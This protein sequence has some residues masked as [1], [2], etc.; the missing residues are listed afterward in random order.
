MCTHE[1]TSEHPLFVIMS[2]DYDYESLPTN[3]VGVHMTAGAVA[4][5]MEHCIMYPF[6]SVKVLS[7]VA[8]A[9]HTF[10]HPPLL[11]YIT[12]SPPPAARSRSECGSRDATARVG[13]PRRSVRER[14][15]MS[16]SGDVVA[17]SSMPS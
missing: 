10:F 5:I 9:A 1:S 16:P 12:S 15:E 7:A 17:F 6:D 11:F 2:K 4:G 13:F 14:R 8:C 3:S